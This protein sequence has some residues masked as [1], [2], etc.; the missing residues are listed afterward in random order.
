M[1]VAARTLHDVPMSNTGTA[2]H[3]LILANPR[4]F[5]MASRNRLQRIDRLAHANA[6]PLYAVHG[7]TE[8]AAALADAAP[9]P[10]DRVIIIGGDGTLQAAVTELAPLAEK[11]EAPTLCMLGGGRTNF[12]ARDLGS[13]DR[14]LRSLEHLVR[15]PTAWSAAERSVLRVSGSEHGPLYGFFVA[16]A[17]VD[18]VIRDCHAYRARHRGWLRTGHT[19]TPWRLAQLGAQALVGRSRFSLPMLDLEAEGLGALNGPVRVLLLTSLRHE[20]GGLNPYAQRGSGPV[21]LTAVH[22]RAPGFWRRLPALISGRFGDSLTPETGY[23]SGH[24]TRVSVRGLPSI[25]LDGQEFVLDP[26]SPLRI[27]TGPAFRF[28]QP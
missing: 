21:R 9:G 7:P 6:I 14:L 1:P 13:H 20:K 10:A 18:A 25:C 11:N 23:L 16:G 27:E 2:P 17:L 22:A 24:S 19:A 15:H 12:T 3:S 8:I 26:A 4:S 5:R 28:L